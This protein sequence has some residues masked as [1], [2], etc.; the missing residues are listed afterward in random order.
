MPRYFV[1]VLE[2]IIRS[3][4]YKIFSTRISENLYIKNSPGAQFKFL[5]SGFASAGM[6]G[7][8]LIYRSRTSA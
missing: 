2:G 4:V 3:R 7:T 1:R 8:T 5:G 6:A